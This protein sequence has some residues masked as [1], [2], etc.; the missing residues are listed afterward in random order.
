MPNNVVLMV[1]IDE[2]FRLNKQRSY[3]LRREITIVTKN[4]DL[5]IIGE[6]HVVIL[7][8]MCGITG[9]YAFN[10]VGG[11]NMVNLAKATEILSKRGPDVQD[12]YHNDHIGLGHR[13]LSIIDTSSDSNQPFW[14]ASQ[15]YCMI[16]NGE[17]Y[18]YQELK[19]EL[20]E[21]G[22]SFRTS[23]DTEVLLYAYIT[24]GEACVDKLNG[25]FAFAIYDKEDR[26]VFIARDRFGIKPLLYFHDEDKFLF[27][28]EMK[29]LLT[30]GIEKQLNYTALYQY[31]QLNYVPA[32][33][34]MLKGVTKLLP[35]HCITIRQGDVKVR[36]YYELKRNARSV[37]QEYDDRKK[38]LKRLLTESV[39]KRMVA[40]VPLGSFLSGG[41]DSSVIATLASKEN[42]DLHTFSIGFADE[43]FFDESSYAKSVAKKIGA[44]HTVFSLTNK[45]LYSHLDNILK[46]IDEPFADSSAIAVYIL[47]KETRK[48]ATVALS[49]DGADE[50]FAGYNKH[51]AFYRMQHQGLMEKL[52]GVLSPLWRIL[53]KSRSNALTN[54]FRQLDRFSQGMKQSPTNRYWSWA[55]FVSEDNAAQM[56]SPESQD[57][58]DHGSYKSHKD[59]LLRPFH[60]SS[61]MT[62]VLATDMKMVL[63]NDMLTKVD[64]M[65]MANSLEV[66]V[67]F[68]DHELVEYVFS[69]PD[70]DKI[71]GNIQKKI[72][73]DTFRD[74]LPEELYNR[75]KKGFE[76]P[77]LKWFRNEM[78]AMIIDDLLADQFVLDQ[79]V[80]NLKRINKL[81]KKLFSSSPGDVH[82]QIWALIVFQSWWKRY[83]E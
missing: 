72:L 82:A 24:Y 62:A 20:K 66:R 30:Y 53:P 29:S 48:H 49:G 78:K 33:H 34:T 61:D 42:P 39:Q 2:G 44:N 14:D 71:D 13:R 69:L 23:S 40:D 25:F 12:I 60:E 35:G 28:S 68:L 37:A 10:M 75:P 83:M 63:P 45:D 47:S 51:A 59:Q 76:V 81:K 74:I 31:L 3:L 41:I 70:K 4:C 6:V 57:K 55:G 9:I 11:F 18:N 67:P 21:R 36:Q 7:R 5:T 8:P 46:Y 58:I 80:F 50:M 73:Q 43:P 15:R 16:F 26:S 22:V 56:L 64:L 38:E 32:P 79:G 19:S 27:A 65:S 1:M 77:L 52:V 54:K 17:I